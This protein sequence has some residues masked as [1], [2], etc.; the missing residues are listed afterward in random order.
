MT[1]GKVIAGDLYMTKIGGKEVKVQ[2][3]SKSPKGGWKA[4]NLRTK[5]EVVIKKAEQLEPCIKWQ[6]E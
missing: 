4:Q 6:I 3:L 2:I 1:N 5:R